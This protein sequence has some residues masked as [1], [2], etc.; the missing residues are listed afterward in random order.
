MC[1]YCSTANKSTSFPP[2]LT[3]NNNFIFSNNYKSIVD[4]SDVVKSIVISFY[5]EYI[6]KTFD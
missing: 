1:I 2:M 4:D 5:V 6:Y 3:E